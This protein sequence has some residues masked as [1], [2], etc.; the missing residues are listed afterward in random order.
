MNEQLG[1][2]KLLKYLRFLKMDTVND[3][4]SLEEIARL[5][6]TD[7][8]VVRYEI[9]ILT[10]TT[11]DSLDNLPPLPLVEEKNGLYKITSFGHGCYYGMRYI[12]MIINGAVG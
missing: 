11:K 7:V 5:M 4:H 12:Y 6:D 3:G 1:I 9:G 8:E 10:S 2:N